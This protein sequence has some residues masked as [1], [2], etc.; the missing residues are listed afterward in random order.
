MTKNRTKVPKNP[1]PI[2]QITPRQGHLRFWPPE[3]PP[4][5]PRWPKMGVRVQIWGV[6]MYVQLLYHLWLKMKWSKMMVYNE[7]YN[8][9]P[10]PLKSTISQTIFHTAKAQSKTFSLIYWWQSFDLGHLS[11]DWEWRQWGRHRWGKLLPPR[12]R[13]GNYQE[14]HP[15]IIRTAMRKI[16]RKIAATTLPACSI[17]FHFRIKSHIATFFRLKLDPKVHEGRL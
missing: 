16:I 3:A 6:L 8:G 17:V 1:Y 9:A 12:S 2:F 15:K 11:E 14:N 4:S 5:V 13:P 10:L 7:K